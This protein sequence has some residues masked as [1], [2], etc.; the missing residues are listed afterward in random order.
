M[1]KS[2]YEFGQEMSKLMPRFLK[3]VFKY[4][5]KTRGGGEVTMPQMSILNILKQEK[6][7]KMKDIARSLS[8]TTSAATG[9]VGRMVKAHLIKRAFDSKDRRIIY[10]EMTQKGS[11]IIDDIQKARY[12]MLI[13]L[14]GKLKPIERERYLH[15]VRKLYNIMTRGI[16]K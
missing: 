13:D 4:F 15:T 11:N 1:D 9:I 5:A 3:E 7:L 2:L 10:I 6:Q 8:I 14:F 12:K 16:N